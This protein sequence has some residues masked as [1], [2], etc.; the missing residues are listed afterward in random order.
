MWG[1]NSPLCRSSRSSVCWGKVC[2]KQNNTRIAFGLWI[3]VWFWQ[4]DYVMNRQQLHLFW[5]RSFI[6]QFLQVQVWREVTDSAKS[7]SDGSRSDSWTQYAQFLRS[8][9]SGIHP[10]SSHRSHFWHTS[11]CDCSCCFSFCSLH[12]LCQ[13]RGVGVRR[14]SPR[15]ARQSPVSSQGCFEEDSRV[16]GFESCCTLC[17]HELIGWS[18][19]SLLLISALVFYSVYIWKCQVE[20][21]SWIVNILLDQGKN[22]SIKGK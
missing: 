16:C 11:H 18:Q 19:I 14:P 4:K 10:H 8:R 1:V 2:P 15:Q 21:M 20:K 6:V 22:L 13:A 5:D 3:S 17:F 9:Q 12:S 7:L